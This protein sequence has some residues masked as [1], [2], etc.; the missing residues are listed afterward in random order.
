MSLTMKSA[1]FVTA[2]I[3]EIAHDWVHANVKADHS[4]LMTMV[5][6]VFRKIE[7]IVR[8]SADITVGFHKAQVYLMECE[9]KGR[10]ALFTPQY[11]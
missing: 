5:Q 6:T 8:S 2:T 11:Q 10:E 3:R 4:T 7:V 9:A 1:T